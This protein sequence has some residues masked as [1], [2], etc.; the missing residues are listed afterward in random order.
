MS[1]GIIYAL[2]VFG[3]NRPTAIDALRFAT[4]K[5]VVTPLCCAFGV[6]TLNKALFLGGGTLGGVG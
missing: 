3:L 4:W 2:A 6:F 1:L 5:I